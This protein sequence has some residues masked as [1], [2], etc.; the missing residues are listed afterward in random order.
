[1]C[2]KKLLKTI[3]EK[4]NQLIKVGLDHGLDSPI[5]LKHSQELDRLLNYLEQLKRASKHNKNTQ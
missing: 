1:M 4:R 2:E 3:E 5:V